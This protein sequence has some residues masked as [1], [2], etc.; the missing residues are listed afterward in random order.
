MRPARKKGEMKKAWREGLAGERKEVGG[1]WDLGLFSPS[2]FG[3]PRLP[4][5]PG[6]LLFPSQASRPPSRGP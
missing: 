1:S 6:L 2:P 3:C 5:T 4:E